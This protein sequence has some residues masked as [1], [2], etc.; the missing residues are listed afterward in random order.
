MPAEPA[1][2]TETFVADAAP[3]AQNICEQVETYIEERPV[4]AM[5]MALLAGFFFSRIV[6]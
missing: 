2:D 6:L 4:R 5:L 3:V 1:T